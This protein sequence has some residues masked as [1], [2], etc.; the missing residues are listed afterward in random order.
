[1]KI[2]CPLRCLQKCL[3]DFLF[4]AWPCLL[5]ASTKQDSAGPKLIP[6]G[7]QETSFHLPQ[8]DQSFLPLASTCQGTQACI[9]TNQIFLHLLLRH[10]NKIIRDSEP[11]SSMLKCCWAGSLK[12]HTV[13]KRQ[14]IQTSIPPLLQ[15]NSGKFSFPI[16]W[17]LSQIQFHSQEQTY[18]F[19]WHL[20]QYRQS[21]L[22]LGS[23]STSVQPA[24]IDHH[25]W[26]YGEQ[27]QRPPRVAGPLYIAMQPWG[28]QNMDKRSQIEVQL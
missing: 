15:K 9:Q 4:W 26:A 28:A 11:Y 12:S 16:L 8:E 27:I 19:L 3:S 5:W 2:L 21:S 10:V 18:V 20:C 17:Q 13:T 24:A 22:P 7:H 1:M 14:Q 6:Q 23:L 25:I